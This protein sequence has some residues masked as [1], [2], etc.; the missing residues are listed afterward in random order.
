MARKHG[1]RSRSRAGMLPGESKRRSLVT[2]TRDSLAAGSD[3]FGRE[4]HNYIVE[5]RRLDG[6]WSH[7][8]EYRGQVWNIPGKV[9]ERLLAQRDS[10][11]KEERSTRAKERMQTAVREAQIIA[12]GQ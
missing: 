4:T 1:T 8:V 5:T 12:Q 10:V 11:I 6:F 9:A 2:I 3:Q 7:Q